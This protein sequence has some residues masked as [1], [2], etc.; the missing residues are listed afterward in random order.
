MMKFSLPNK[1]NNFIPQKYYKSTP[2]IAESKSPKQKENH[3]TTTIWSLFNLILL[4]LSLCLILALTINSRHKLLSPLLS[5]REQLQPLKEAK[6]SHEVFGFAP[7]WTFDKLDNVDYSTLT[8]FAYFGIEVLRDGTLD[9]TGP[10]YDTFMSEKATTTF[11]K[12]HS[13]GTRVVLTVTQMDSDNLDALLTDQTAQKHAIDEIVSLVK[14]RGIDGVNVDF[15]Y[16]G[17]PAQSY[18]QAYTD[19]LAQLNS[20]LKQSIPNSQLTI[21]VYASAAKAT[22]LYDIAAIAPHV[23]GIFMMA[24]DFYSAGADNA[25][26]TA[27]LNGAKNGKYS[28]DIA[29]AVDDFLKKIPAEKLILGV[30]YYGYSYLMYEPKPFTETRPAYSWRGKPAAQ[31]IAYV[32]ENVTADKTGWDND[33]KVAWQAHYTADTDTWRMIFLEDEK[34]L[35]IKYDFAKSKGLKGVGMWA[36]GFDDGTSKYWALLKEK[37]GTKLADSRAIQAN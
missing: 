35:G 20:Q 2:N 14:A 3:N 4:S 27:P 23:D 36:L 24:Y 19:F 29:T 26:P 31:T 28:Y 21:S 30:P 33:G 16:D 13:F 12:A 22:R 32:S 25:M 1:L 11:R 37:F 5:S 6:K 18:S 15:E 17:N 7:Y 10:G 34:S 8:T 9:T